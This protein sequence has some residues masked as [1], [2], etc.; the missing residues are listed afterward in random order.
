MPGELTVNYP[1]EIVDY[2]W[3]GYFGPSE[4]VWFNFTI[5]DGDTLS[6]ISYVKV[7]VYHRQ[8]SS[9]DADNTKKY[10][11]TFMW[12]WSDGWY[13]VD[14]TGHLGQNYAPTD[15][16]VNVG[17]WK[18]EIVCDKECVSGLWAIYLEVLDSKN[19]MATLTVNI[20][21]YG[22]YDVV[23]KSVIV[24]IIGDQSVAKAYIEVTNRNPKYGPDVTLVTKITDYNSTLAEQNTTIQVPAAYSSLFSVEMYF[25]GEV[26]KAYTFVAYVVDP[27]DIS[28][29][30]ATYSFMISVPLAPPPPAIP[31]SVVAVTVAGGMNLFMIISLV[32]ILISFIVFARPLSCM[33]K[34]KA[35][36]CICLFSNTFMAL[37]IVSLMMIIF[38]WLFSAYIPFFLTIT[39]LILGIILFLISLVF[40]ILHGGKCPIIK[41]A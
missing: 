19:A 13:E 34:K 24:T 11:Y 5:R 36:Q 15:P 4:H 33:V 28:T 8:Y 37:A 41:I 16:T 12:T 22:P 29:P 26:G 10:H 3:E 21:G 40:L 39:S 30:P 17:D 1:P 31:P 7:V 32:F 35:I 20:E 23:I 9:L 38:V 6:D 2:S 14:L 18:L 27:Y 25:H